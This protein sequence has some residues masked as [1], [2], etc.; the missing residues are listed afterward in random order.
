MIAQ[1]RKRGA[2]NRQ[3]VFDA[4]PESEGLTCSTLAKATHLN[5]KTVKRHLDALV[6]TG[7]IEIEGTGRWIRYR[8]VE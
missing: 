3:K 4:V 1:S 8:R 6:G 7:S 5:D 2:E